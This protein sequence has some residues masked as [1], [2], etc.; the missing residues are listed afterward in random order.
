MRTLVVGDIHGCW[1][2]FQELLLKAELGGGD[3]IVALGDIVDRGPDSVSVLDFFQ[4]NV[5]AKSLMGNHERKHVRSFRNEVR[6]AISQRITR[7]QLGEEAYPSACAFMDSF[8]R[9]IDRPE[10]ILVH[11]FFEPGIALPE[12]RETVI[13]GTL[14]GE[15][16]MVKTYSRPWYE[17]YD[18]EKPILVGHR[19][20]LGTGEPLIY[21]DR[22]YGID[23]A[24]YL[25]RA[26][27]G[28]VLPEFRLISVKSRK[29]YWQETRRSHPSI[30]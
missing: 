12:Q 10:A 20:Y 28:L 5:N 4:K 15:K 11:G 9:F 27:T 19:D 30:L 18:G 21:K 25:G 2:E 7:L 14:T 1:T 23:T 13:V 6:P 26:L 17:L 8:P 29:D 3:E 16:H 24:C 22:V